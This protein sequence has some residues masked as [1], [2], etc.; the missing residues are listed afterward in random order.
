MKFLGSLYTENRKDNGTSAAL[1]KDMY[2]KSLSESKVL[3]QVTSNILYMVLE[4]A[5]KGFLLYITQKGK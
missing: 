2:S 1:Y 3:V 5:G 4:E